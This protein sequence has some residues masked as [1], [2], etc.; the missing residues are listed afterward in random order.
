MFIKCLKVGPLPTNCY[1]VCDTFAAKAVIIDPGDEAARILAALKETGCTAKYILLTHGHADHMSAA[2]EV[3]AKTGA[4][5]CVPEGD[6]EF[7]NKPAL[8]CYNML[9]T[10][11][12]VLLKPDIILHDG[13]TISFGNTELRVLETPG[14]TDGSV[15]F[16]GADSMFCGD[17]VFKDGIGRTDLPSG[18]SQKLTNSLKR[19]A[20][21]DGNLQILPGHGEF[22]TLLHEKANNPYFNL[23][24]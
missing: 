12:F 20:A 18:N 21:I 9:S 8:N 15:C 14:H 3:L 11:A 17:T 16:I 1:I 5:L 7:I 19:I 6:K 13:E 23:G 24:A 10:S 22:T 2:N 4:K